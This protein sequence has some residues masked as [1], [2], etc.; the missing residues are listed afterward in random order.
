MKIKCKFCKKEELKRLITEA[1]EM[2][3]LCKKC[4]RIT[5]LRIDIICNI[6]GELNCTRD[7]SFGIF[8][9]LKR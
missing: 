7:H 6:C 9:F 4:G 5:T 3:F 8:D 1:N 2:F